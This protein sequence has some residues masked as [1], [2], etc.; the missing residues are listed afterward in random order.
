MYS[1]VDEGVNVWRQR[2]Q[3]V[4][5]LLLVVPTLGTPRNGGGD[6]SCDP[7]FSRLFAPSRPL[8]GRYE[9]CASPGPIDALIKPN[10]VVERVP[11]LEAFGMAGAYD[12][13]RMA[14]L[15]GAQR[16]TVARSWSEEQGR[17][18]SLTLISPY[19]DPTLTRLETGTLI[20]RFIICCT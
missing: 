14:R 11:P 9:I 3:V 1:P 13:S 18:E 6:R 8:V 17:F 20:V 5:A 12:R 15:Y 16:A 10:W 7:A 19:P 4:L 2:A